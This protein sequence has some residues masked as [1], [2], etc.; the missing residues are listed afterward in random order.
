MKYLEL[1]QKPELMEQVRSVQSEL[2]DAAFRCFRLCRFDT[3][4][5][6]YTEGKSC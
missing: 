2:S 5:F 1:G 3:G 6:L 4:E